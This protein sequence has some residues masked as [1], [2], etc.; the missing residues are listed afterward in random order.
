M[1]PRAHRGRRKELTPP[2]CLLFILFYFPRC[3]LN[4]SVSIL[5]T[6][7]PGN[8][9]KRAH[10]AYQLSP[11]LGLCCLVPVPSAQRTLVTDLEANILAE[12]SFSI[13][14]SPEPCIPDY[15]QLKV[16]TEV[17]KIPGTFWG[18]ERV[19]CSKGENGRQECLWACS[20]CT[21]V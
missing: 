3:L 9:R 19:V 16:I 8:K 10:Y 4:S 7:K 11:T 5:I 20:D 18:R 15:A 14:R 21:Q 12:N 17:R 6:S 1:I 2:R 13:T